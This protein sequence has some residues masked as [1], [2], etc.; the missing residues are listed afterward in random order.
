MTPTRTPDND[1]GGIVQA[2]LAYKDV[3]PL[4]RALATS[5]GPPVV[6]EVVHDE[7]D[8]AAHNERLA[9]NRRSWFID[10]ASAP[11]VLGVTADVVDQLI[12]ARILAVVRVLDAHGRCLSE[13]IRKDTVDEFLAS[14]RERRSATRDDPD[15]PM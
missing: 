9:A 11:D 14:Q 2:F 7:T 3:S 8:S 12:D 10:K 6:L 5:V 1:I 4:R 13:H 15:E